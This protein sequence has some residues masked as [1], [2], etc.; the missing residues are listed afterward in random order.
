MSKYGFSSAVL[1]VYTIENRMSH[2][3]LTLPKKKKHDL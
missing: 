3:Y 2:A 1:C